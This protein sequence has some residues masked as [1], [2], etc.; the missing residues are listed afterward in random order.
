M[1]DGVKIYWY[2]R[3]MARGS[4]SSMLRILPSS[5]HR[6]LEISLGDLLATS[7]VTSSDLSIDLHSRIRRNEMVGDVIALQDG[8]T[9]IDNSVVFPTNTKSV[10]AQTASG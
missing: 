2:S 7:K 4:N 10:E 8:N 3:R 9:A 5:P 6:V 1:Q